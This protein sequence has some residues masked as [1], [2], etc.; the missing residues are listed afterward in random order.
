MDTS[1]MSRYWFLGRGIGSLI[2]G[3]IAAFLLSYAFAEM[4]PPLQEKSQPL[5]THPEMLLVQCAFYPEDSP[6]I[7]EIE[8]LEQGRIT[9]VAAEGDYAIELL[10]QEGQVL[11]RQRF[12]IL[13]MSMGDP[14]VLADQ[15][16]K[17]FVVP[18][19]KEVTSVRLVTPQGQTEATL[20]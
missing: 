17:T 8:Y 3:A 13:F 11:Y 2:V 15:V 5:Q 9:L 16:D 10:D 20:P 6:T 7:E 14:P 12:D 19:N 4:A 1:G 18:Y